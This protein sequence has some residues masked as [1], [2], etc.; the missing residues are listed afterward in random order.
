MVTH[1]YTITQARFFGE[2][3]LPKWGGVGGNFHVDIYFASFVYMCFL[4][5]RKHKKFV[6]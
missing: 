6:D 5:T 3:K 1:R 4:L 2:E